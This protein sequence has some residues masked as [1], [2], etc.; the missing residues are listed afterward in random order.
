MGWGALRWGIV[1]GSGVVHGGG[2][3]PGCR[4][5]LAR[6]SPGGPTVAA[7]ADGD[8]Y[9]SLH[10]RD[11]RE[12]GRT[13]AGVPLQKISGQYVVRE[14]Q[15]MAIE[16]SE[17]VKSCPFVPMQSHFGPQGA[18]GY[19]CR[20]NA[21]FRVW[22][23]LPHQCGVPRLGMAAASMRRSIS[24]PERR[25][26]AAG[27]QPSQFSDRPSGRE[28]CQESLS[29]FA[30]FPVSMGGNKVNVRLPARIRVQF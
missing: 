8:Y 27:G 5:G 15:N 17:M 19:C 11:F 6:A 21:A 12:R 2:A 7:V 26:Y 22:E 10:A 4:Q 28:Q 25:I 24:R 29:H 23:L 16:M 1:F 18:S 30:I 20:I 9:S 3:D 14:G 13:S